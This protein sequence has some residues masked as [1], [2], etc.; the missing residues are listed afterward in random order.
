MR[1]KS[2]RFFGLSTGSL[3]ANFRPRVCIPQAELVR[4]RRAVPSRRP[5]LLTPA[6]RALIK[7][8]LAF[9]LSL[10]NGARKPTTEAQRHFAA[11]CRDAA[12]PA[13]PHE[14]AFVKWKALREGK[15]R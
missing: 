15:Q 6:E 4:R 1:G 3:P 7:K 2:R 14:V 11:V 8:H 9:Y 12:Q 13:T 5:V 10:A